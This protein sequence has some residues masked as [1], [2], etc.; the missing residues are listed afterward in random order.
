MFSVSCRQYRRRGFNPWGGK[1]SWRRKWQ[2]TLV[3]LPGK[4]RGWRSL[5]GYSSWGRKESDTTE[6]LHSLTQ[7]WSKVYGRICVGYIQI[8][9][10]YLWNLSILGFRCLWK[11]LEQIQGTIIHQESRKGEEGAV[12]C[13]ASIPRHTSKVGCWGWGMLTVGEKRHRGSPGAGEVWG[14]GSSMAPSLAHVGLMNQSEE[15]KKIPGKF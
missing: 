8:P 2:S 1:I 4:S 10:P 9:C 15:K 12:L 11:D 13:K 6:R 14:Q 3:F 5:V 7:R